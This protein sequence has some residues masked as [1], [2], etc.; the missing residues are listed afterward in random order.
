MMIIYEKSHFFDKHC[1]LLSDIFIIDNKVNFKLISTFHIKNRNRFR[2]N[3]LY[4]E[5]LYLK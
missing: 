2:V 1:T 3:Y 5:K 4:L